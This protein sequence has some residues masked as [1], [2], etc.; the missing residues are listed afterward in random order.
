MAFARGKVILLGEHSVVYGRPALAAA[1]GIGVTATASPASADV[2]RVT[3]WGVSIA[4]S[5][6][7]EEPL[8]RAF[9]AVLAGYEGARSPLASDADCALPAGAG[10]GCSAAVGV[11]VLGAIDEALG[12][13]RT[14]EARGEA[15]LVWEKVFHGNP[16]GVDNAM[17]ACGGVAVYTRGKPLAPVRVARPLP[18]VICHS[19]E[20][21]L[22]KTTVAHVARFHARE[23]KR[24]EETF[25]AIA[26]IVINGRNAVEQGDLKHLGQLF[27]MNHMLLSTML[28]STDRLEALCKAARTAGALGAKLTGGGGGGCMIALAEDTNAAAEIAR[29]LEN[30]GGKPFVVEAGT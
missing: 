26:A 6:D 29:A 28:L 19:G 23:Q 10:L 24:A 12:I 9:A 27:D 17:A 21:S 7:A 13:E 5:H 25:D 22:T 30:E 14:N 2:L 4:P 16:S 11:A 1:L 20:P 8:A 3:P 15:A 18:L